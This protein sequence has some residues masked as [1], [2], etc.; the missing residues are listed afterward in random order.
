MLSERKITRAA[1]A[2]V[3]I[4]LAAIALMAWLGVVVVKYW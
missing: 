1:A 3:L 2:L 4:V